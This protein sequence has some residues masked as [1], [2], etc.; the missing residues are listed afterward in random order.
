MENFSQ[1]QFKEFL[2]QNIDLIL[3]NADIILL[4]NIE[5][6]V[7]CTGSRFQHHNGVSKSITDAAGTNLIQEFNSYLSKNSS[8][9]K[10]SI[11]VTPAYNLNNYKHILH[12]AT[13]TYISDLEATYKKI[14]DTCFNQL[15][16]VS[17]AVPIIGSG[18]HGLELNDSI[19]PLINCLGKLSFSKKC[20]VIIANNDTDKYSKSL[21]IIKNILE[22]KDELADIECPICLDTIKE[23]KILEICGHV[24]CTRCIDQ[25]LKANNTCPYCKQSYGQ[26]IGNQPLGNMTYKLL[27]ISLPGFDNC[28]KTIEIKYEFLNGIQ[29]PEHPNPGLAYPGTMRIAYLPDNSEGKH[30]LSLL[31]KA[32]QQKLIFTIGRSRTIGQ[33]NLI[34]W[35]DID[36]KT[37]ISGGPD[38]F[39]YPD[40]YYLQRVTYQLALKGIK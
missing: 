35:G 19:E 21:H 2:N 14:F 9:N 5:C 32:F 31:K 7:N 20:Q 30:V 8:L 12:V 4:S 11:L 34:T 27:D 29:G 23:P 17:I 40:Q 6:V 28:V 10:N 1:I 39:G 3:L 25:C 18:Q 33:D 24:F 37:N 26:Q 15:N 16:L 13:P 36:H 38:N 22:K